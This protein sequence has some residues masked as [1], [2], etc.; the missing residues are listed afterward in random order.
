[1]TGPIQVDH[2]AVVDLAN[3]M[4]ELS[5]RAQD[6]LARYS[7]AVQH[8]QSAQILNGTAGNTSVVT[9]A[10]IHDAQMKIQSRFQSVNDLL[11]SGA[12]TYTNTD[13]DAAQAVASVGSH[14]RF[15]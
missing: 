10:E 5:H 7:D 14:I 6:V 9:G 12:S 8:A 1:M 15:Q 13:H 2:G 4:D 11:R 3:K